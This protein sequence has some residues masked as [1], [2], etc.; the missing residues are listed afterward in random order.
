MMKRKTNKLLSILLCCVLLLGLLPVTATAGGPDMTTLYFCDFQSDESVA[1]WLFGDADH[2]GYGWQRYN[3]Y[4]ETDEEDGTDFAIKSASYINYVGP[5]TPDNWAY[6]PKIDLSENGRITLTYTVYAQDPEYYAEHYSV[7]VCEL[8]KEPVKLLEETL[9]EDEDINYR[10]TRSLDL[11]AWA[12]KTIQIAFR[13]HDV[14]DQF[15]LAIDDISVVCVKSIESVSVTVDEPMIGMA[16]RSFGEVA[17]GYGG[18][19]VANVT[20]D[21]A[22]EVFQAEKTYSVL[23]TLEAIDGY[24]FPEEILLP[25]INGHAATVVTK[26]A[27]EMKLSYTFEP[28]KSPMPSMFFDDV[29]TTNWFYHDVEFVYYNEIMNGI[30]N[31]KFDPYGQCNRGMVVTILYRLEGEPAHSGVN[32]YNDVPDKK[33]YTDAVIWATDNGIVNGTVPGKFEPYGVATREQLVTILCRYA[34]MKG[35]FN[36]EDCVMLAGFA[37]SDKVAIWAQEAMSWAVGA[38]LIRGITE[39]DGQYLQPKGDAYRCQ[40]AA[41]I[42]RFV[43]SFGA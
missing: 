37:D 8:G 38:G 30:G 7:Y 42:H 6:S 33:W 31:N 15:Y 23:V 18:Y 14:T 19:T 27:E 4:M 28:L 24:F 32:P 35:V 41:M 17:S 10:A 16:V 39:S 22:D 20:W 36:E 21:P 34:R 3:Q 43:D 2:D 40:V 29:K 13:H 26:S 1:G 12:G 25:Y 11:S 5:L 9:Q